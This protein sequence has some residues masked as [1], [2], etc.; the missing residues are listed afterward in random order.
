MQNHSKNNGVFMFDYN[1]WL[2][3]SVGIS[4]MI[5]VSLIVFTYI[6]YKAASFHDKWLDDKEKK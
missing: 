4:F 3:F 6:I 5:I 1:F 2:G